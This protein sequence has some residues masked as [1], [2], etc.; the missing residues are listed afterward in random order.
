M[1]CVA[2]SSEAC[3]CKHELTTDGTVKLAQADGTA[4]EAKV[5]GV[6]LNTTTMLGQPVS[7]A[8]KGKFRWATGGFGSAGKLLV[9]TNSAGK[10]QDHGRS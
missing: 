9:L 3:G 5:H 1:F 2:P 4:A 10:I 7:V 6:A 8:L